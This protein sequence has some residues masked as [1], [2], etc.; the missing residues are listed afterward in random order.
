[1]KILPVNQNYNQ[2]RQDRNVNF[3]AVLV[4]SHFELFGGINS[5]A[6]SLLT[7]I[8][9]SSPTRLSALANKTRGIKPGYDSPK[10]LLYHNPV[11][12]RQEIYLSRK[13]EREL[14]DALVAANQAI[15]DDY[16]K[17]ERQGKDCL[18]LDNIGQVI[19][20][21]WV[22]PRGRMRELRNLAE[23][24]WAEGEKNPIE[25]VVTASASQLAKANEKVRQEQ[26]VIDS[27]LY[28]ALNGRRFP[29]QLELP[30]PKEKPK[31]V[32]RFASG[33]VFD[34]SSPLRLWG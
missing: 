15:K 32:I 16:K 21:L 14:H 33:E 20:R 6:D 4:K 30:F 23:R 28:A 25:H 31:R 19:N 26:R 8:H 22:A 34:P 12:R 24:L 11:E 3:S 18:D 5:L 17:Q 7:G 10:D 29:E 27:D 9:F 2:K 1:M 13:Q